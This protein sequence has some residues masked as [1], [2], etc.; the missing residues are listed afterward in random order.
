MLA[1][2]RNGHHA[3]AAADFRS[4]NPPECSA[5]TCEQNKCEAEAGWRFTWPGRNEMLVCRECAK[6]ASRVADA[7]GFDLQVIPLSPEAQR[8][9]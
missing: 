5:V 2:R 9:P 6:K 7:M 8:E 1:F 4:L 3:S